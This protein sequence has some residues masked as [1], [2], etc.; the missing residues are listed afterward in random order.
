MTSSAASDRNEPV[1]AYVQHRS[2]CR[3]REEGISVLH[4]GSIIPACSCGLDAALAT[5]RASG[6]GLDWDRL[7]E[8]GFLDAYLNISG[9]RDEAEAERL[10]RED[11]ATYARLT[12]QPGEPTDDRDDYEVR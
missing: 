5:E 8:A 4:D 7:V 1:A 9:V 10:L 3:Q 6:A 11:M 2:Y 12:P